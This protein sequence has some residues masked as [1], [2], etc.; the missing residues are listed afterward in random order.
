MGGIFVTGTDTEVGKTWASLALLAALG[1]RGLA[2]AAMKPV[3]SGGFRREGRLVNDDALALQGAATVAAPYERV[4][5]YVFEPPVA[6]HLAA[7]GAGTPIRREPILEAAGALGAGAQVLV[8]EGVGGWR[9][10]L[11][12]DWDVAALARDLGLPV[13]LVVGIRLGCISHAL[14]TAESIRAAG[15]TLAGWVA[16]RIDPATRLAAQVVGAVAERIDAPLLADMPH[17]P[18][19]PASAQ[20]AGIDER[21]LEALLRSL[22]T[23]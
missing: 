20:E 23:P 15:C 22:D 3:A 1:E 11:A 16:T 9:V 5:P 17:L 2:T 4:N 12:E 10:P 21:A 14:L 6:P 18:R 19:P 13:V 8:V 7:R